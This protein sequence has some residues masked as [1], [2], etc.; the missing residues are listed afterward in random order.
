M[1]QAAPSI[2]VSID[3][4]TNVQILAVSEDQLS[5]FQR[6][7]LSVI[8]ERSG[9]T[10]PVVVERLQAMLEAGVI[11][12][13]R[14][15]LIANRL[16]EGALVAWQVS[17]ERLNDGFDYLFQQDPASGHV[18]IRSTD[19]ETPGAN[20]RLWTTLKVPQ[21]YSI[22]RHCEVLARSIGAEAF[23]VMP[24]KALFTLGVGHVRR[25]GTEPGSR[26]NEPGQ[27]MLDEIV[28]LDEIEWQ[29]LN[30]LKG[31][32]DASEVA[33][34]LWRARAVQAGLTFE[35]FC[36]VAES[37]DERGVLG[38]FSTFL[39]HSKPL[40]GGERV[41]SY[42][43]LFHW[44]VPEGKELEA[45]REVGRH[46][47]MTHAYW[48]ESGPEFGN[49][50]IMGVAHS[51]TDRQYL[52]DHK[53]AIDAHLEEASIPVL[54]SSVFWGGRSEIKPSEIAPEAY[55]Q[56]CRDNGIEPASMRVD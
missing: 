48:R 47:I 4:P 18:V 11:R 46:D 10:V 2:P 9:V 44:A 3:D 31:E 55:E 38:R 34:D 15:T 33:P 28:P 17:R 50:N 29:V 35:R 36:E 19:A 12:R 23:R 42:N 13:I 52:L 45:G 8:A 51:S 6:D 21:G 41:T 30:A 22:T 49:V 20:F 24:A 27:T 54:Y 37:L 1:T 16:A 7:P 25:R 56:W 5:G 26:S 32:L 39:E 53:A 40:P 43:A 14:Q